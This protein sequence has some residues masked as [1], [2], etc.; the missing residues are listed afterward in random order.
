MATRKMEEEGRSHHFTV[1]VAKETKGES[2]DAFLYP[3]GASGER[4]QMFHL[5]SIDR[6]DLRMTN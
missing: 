1:N 3:A 6:T 2:A 5:K 4:L